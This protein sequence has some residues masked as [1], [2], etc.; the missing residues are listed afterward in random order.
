MLRDKEAALKLE[1]DVTDRGRHE[2]IDI[3]VKAFELSQSLRQ[4]WLTADYA[5]KRCL[6]EIIC[7]NCTL[8]DVSLVPTMRKPFDLL[9]KGLVSK[10]SRGNQTRLELFGSEFDDWPA[11][12]LQSMFDAA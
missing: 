2:I 10:N 5:A 3:A 1:I 6:L 9:T 7:L 4:K 12:I 8:D 11:K